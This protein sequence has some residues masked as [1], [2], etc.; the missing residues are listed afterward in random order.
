MGM[1]WSRLL[2]WRGDR[3]AALSLRSVVPPV[4]AFLAAVGSLTVA[5]C[6]SATGV[7]GGDNLIQPT[8]SPSPTP[9]PSPTPSPI[10]TPL[11]T[12]RASLTV[13]WPARSRGT[14]A[15][16][17]SA[18]S[19]RVTLIGA[20]PEGQDIT[21]VVHRRADPSA[22]SAAYSAPTDALVGAWDLQVRFYA[23][24]DGSG[25]VVGVAEARVTMAADGSLPDI[26]TTGRIH[27]VEVSPGQSVLAGERKDLAFT[28]RGDDGA[29]LALTPGSAFVAVT[30]G[31]DR[32]RVQEGQVEGLLPGPA[33]VTVAIDGLVSPA[34]PVAVTSNAVVSV[35][36]TPATV[37]IRGG[38]R[39]AATVANAPDNAV[40]WAVQEGAV[41]GTIADDG[42]YTAPATPGT[43]H[44]VATSVYDPSK[45]TVVTV[46]VQAGGARVG[47]N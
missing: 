32:L 21:F 8:P 42:A 47:I 2:A 10:P 9:T 29:L 44:I 17:A 37:P 22:Y 18:L 43:F 27:S 5:G 4:L 34:A 38:Q 16:L 24:G 28:A 11:P 40:T 13:V 39:F 1:I 35:T 14:V 45:Q 19:A 26:A 33:S 30:G 36:P 46:T 20:S 25:D 15:S 12:A 3:R 23:Q 41:G 7:H 6:G 31:A